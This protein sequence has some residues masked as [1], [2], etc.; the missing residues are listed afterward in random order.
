MDRFAPVVHW[1]D[2]LD[3]NQVTKRYLTS[4]D[5]DTRLVF[6]AWVMKPIFLSQNRMEMCDWPMNWFEA[7]KT[8]HSRPNHSKK[9]WRNRFVKISDIELTVVCIWAS[10]ENLIMQDY[11]NHCSQWVNVSLT[12][13]LLWAKI[14][15]HLQIWY[16]MNCEENLALQV[17]VASISSYKMMKS[18]LAS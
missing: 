10:E 14:L 12:W 1:R 2:F 17:L 9:V 6:K 4:F 8:L 11:E 13:V 7:F 16:I 15:M 5:A 3:Q 18:W